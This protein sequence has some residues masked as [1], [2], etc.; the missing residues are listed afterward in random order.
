MR[1]YCAL[2]ALL[3][4]SAACERAVEPQLAA[5]L[6]ITPETLLVSLDSTAHVVATIKNAGGGDLIRPIT[7]LMLDTTTAT[8]DAG[9]VTG[10]AVGQT[11]LVVATDS[12]VAR[13]PVRVF[14]KLSAIAVS[15]YSA[16]ALS[17]EGRPLCWG[18]SVGYPTRP[19]AGPLRLASI[20]PADIKACGLTTTGQAWCFPEAF[21]PGVPDSVVPGGHMFRALT[22]TAGLMCG[23]DDGGAM[24]CWGQP[25]SFIVPGASALLTSPTDAAPG[26]HFQAIA[27]HYWHVCGLDAAGTAWCWG[28]NTY[29]QAGDSANSVTGCGSK[30]PCTDHPVRIPGAPALTAITVGTFH[31]CG[32]TAAGDA[33]CWG[34]NESGQL[35]D[36]AI[37]NCL[38]AK[39]S[40]G[41]PCSQAA[42]PVRGGHHFTSITAGAYHTCALE[43]DGSAWCWGA[44]GG[45]FGDGTNSIG[46]YRVTQAGVGMRFTS[47]RAAYQVTC[48]MAAVDHRAYCWGDNTFNLLG[49]GPPRGDVQLSPGPVLYQP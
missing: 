35:G 47:L 34:D 16:C 31:S 28:Y 21:K 15:D 36:T 29:G 19:F 10:R 9:T 41:Y 13:I 32:L 49:R 14:V 20:E 43:V 48:G 42:I 27:G 5:S 6:Q 39:F 38:N 46:N 22:H 44:N 12:L 4:L 26:M 40:P 37:S 33:W 11:E 3:A 25:H 24:L 23:L 30:G 8:V 18:G 45:A 2:P 1:V 7:W 17:D